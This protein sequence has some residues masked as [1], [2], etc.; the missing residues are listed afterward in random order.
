MPCDAIKK[1]YQSMMG[2]IASN[3]GYV[4]YDAMG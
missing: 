1:T 3:G 4:A 2:E